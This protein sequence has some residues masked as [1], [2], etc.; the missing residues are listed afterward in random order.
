M[1]NN[2][3]Y[4]GVLIENNLRDETEICSL[5]HYFLQIVFLMSKNSCLLATVQI[6]IAFLCSV[7]LDRWFLNK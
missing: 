5:Q 7:T 6:L 3:K 2:A 4:L 1:S